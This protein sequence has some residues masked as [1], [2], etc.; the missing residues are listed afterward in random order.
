VCACA[1]RVHKDSRFFDGWLAG[2]LEKRK[3]KK[4]QNSWC[5]GIVPNKRAS[6][7][8]RDIEEE[9]GHGGRGRG[10]DSFSSSS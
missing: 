1:D 6:M 2:W 5:I 10:R 3:K 7:E 4:E 9:G 8:T